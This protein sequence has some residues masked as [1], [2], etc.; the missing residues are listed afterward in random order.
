MRHSAAGLIAPV[1]VKLLRGAMT[2]ENRAQS[3]THPA[4][5]Q[6]AGKTGNIS[7]RVQVLR[8]KATDL[9]QT[10]D[11]IEGTLREAQRGSKE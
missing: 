9:S 1:M 6:P 8:E 3:K 11:K 2:D 4:P 10:L 5:S 7:D